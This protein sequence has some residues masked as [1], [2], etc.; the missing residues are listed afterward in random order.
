MVL[1]DWAYREAMQSSGLCETG[2]TL[3]LKERFL[4]ISP[5]F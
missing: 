2:F 1:L 4:R 5:S 3:F